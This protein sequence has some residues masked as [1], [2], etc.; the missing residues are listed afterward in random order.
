M[1]A[2]GNKSFVV[3]NAVFTVKLLYKTKY[4]NMQ[5]HKITLRTNCTI[6]LNNIKIASVCLCHRQHAIGDRR[7][8]LAPCDNRLAATSARIRLGDTLCGSRTVVS[9][10]SAL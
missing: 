5:Y 4:K 8:F 2:N 3:V 7:Y 6:N 10:S 1:V 9:V